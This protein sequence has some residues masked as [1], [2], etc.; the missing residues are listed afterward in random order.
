M[1]VWL[2]PP[3]VDHLGLPTSNGLNSSDRTALICV[4]RPDVSG[5][6]PG[7]IKVCI[8]PPQLTVEYMYLLKK[9]ATN[10]KQ[11]LYNVY[12]AHACTCILHFF[13]SAM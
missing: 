6:S 8:Y 2:L 3:L 7:T 11:T 12:N 9:L 10:C 5:S 4:V 13:F 1:N